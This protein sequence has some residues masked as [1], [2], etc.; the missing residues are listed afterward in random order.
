MCVCVCLCVCMC[1]CDHL[2]VW[3]GLFMCMFINI[4]YLGFMGTFFLNCIVR[5]LGR[6]RRCF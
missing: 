6:N 1:V 3:L 2:F 5:C 4:Q